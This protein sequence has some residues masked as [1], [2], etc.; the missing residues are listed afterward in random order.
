[1][2]SNYIEFAAKLAL[3]DK[4]LAA[5]R[6]GSN[7]KFRSSAPIAVELDYTNFGN[8]GNFLDATWEIVFL[9]GLSKKSLNL[10]PDSEILEKEVSPVLEFLKMCGERKVKKIFYGS[11]GGAIYG[12][13]R[14]NSFTEDMALSP[15]D[16]YGRTKMLIE[17]DLLNV[18][19]TSETALLLGRIANPYGKISQAEDRGLIANVIKAAMSAMPFTLYG[20]PMAERDY[21]HISDFNFLLQ[22]LL[23]RDCNSIFYNIGTG[24]STSTQQVIE[25]VKKETNLPIQTRLGN[26]EVN[27]VKVSRLSCTRLLHELG[28]PALKTL[29]QGIHQSV[30]DQQGRMK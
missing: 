18:F 2:G 7:T 13:N 1:M 15:L 6:L 12:E 24:Q 23:D 10:L 5:G 30:I 19:R 3:Y 14:G 8:F 9:A 29:G 27:E 22:G 21:I 4:I 25:L 17:N 11:S 20:D 16:N 26:V 28:Y